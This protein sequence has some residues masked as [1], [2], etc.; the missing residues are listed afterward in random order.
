MLFKLNKH[1]FVFELAECDRLREGS[2]THHAVLHVEFWVLLND[3]ASLS[4]SFCVHSVSGT[5][6][7]L[8]RILCI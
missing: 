1:V 5:C 2:A 3:G 4:T 8:N 6:K 7:I